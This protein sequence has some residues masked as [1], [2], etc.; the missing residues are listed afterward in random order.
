MV[1]G[2]GERLNTEWDLSVGS[3][4]CSNGSVEDEIPVYGY[5]ALGERPGNRGGSWRGASMEAV[6]EAPAVVQGSVRDSPLSCCS[7]LCVVYA[8]EVSRAG[9]D[10]RWDA[11]LAADF[12]RISWPQGWVKTLGG[13]PPCISPFGAR[14]VVVAGRG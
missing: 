4:P 2:E 1:L 11:D 3:S 10:T 12:T 7:I 14:Y 8:C 5:G 9:I 13:N 6:G